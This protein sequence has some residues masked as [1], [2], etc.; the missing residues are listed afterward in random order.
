M[1]VLLSLFQLTD[2]VLNDGK[3][4]QQASYIRLKYLIFSYGLMLMMLAAF[5]FIET[6][7]NLILVLFLF[8]LNVTV[9]FTIC[10]EVVSH[11]PTHQKENLLVFHKVSK[12]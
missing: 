4:M 1:L 2:L 12:Y 5:F 3:N 9:A 10:E 7:Q 6:F 11:L 8:C